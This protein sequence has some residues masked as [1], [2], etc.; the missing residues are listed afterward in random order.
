MIDVR[1]DSDVSKLSSHNGHL[2]KGLK[3]GRKVYAKESTLRTVLFTLRPEIQ[4]SV[5]V[6][7]LK[8]HYRH[9]AQ[10]T[11]EL[12]CT[13]FTSSKPTSPPQKILCWPL[14]FS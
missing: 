9:S 5:A 1:D 4:H 12:L 14:K 2:G 11:D 3:D 10:F 13:L 6:T 7:R 8:P